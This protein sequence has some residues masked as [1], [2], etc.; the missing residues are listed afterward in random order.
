MKTLFTRIERFLLRNNRKFI[1]NSSD[2][3]SNT[4]S[5]SDSDFPPEY[6]ESTKGDNFLKL[7]AD[8]SKPKPRASDTA[9]KRSSGFRSR[10]GQTDEFDEPAVN[11]S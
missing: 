8:V 1:L 2:G 9:I 7:L 3:E 6:R 11:F 5:S 10:K 4:S